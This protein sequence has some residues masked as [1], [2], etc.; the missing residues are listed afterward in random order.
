M[1][2]ALLYSQNFEAIE[3]PGFLTR[4]HPFRQPLKQ[5]SYTNPALNTVNCAE[6]E[7]L[8]FAH[9]FS[10]NICKFLSGYLGGIHYHRIGYYDL[11][12]GENMYLLVLND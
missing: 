6:G 4:N 7:F 8:P 2:Y 1:G 9:K 5:A 11:I 10:I 12:G 3:S